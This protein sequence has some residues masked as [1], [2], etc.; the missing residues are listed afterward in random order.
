MIDGEQVNIF[1]GGRKL[2]GIALRE[3][4]QAREASPETRP[5]RSLPHPGLP[6]LPFSTSH[7]ARGE[8]LALPALIASLQGSFDCACS[9]R[10]LRSAQ[11]DRVSCAGTLVALEHWCWSG[12]L[13]R[14]LIW[15]W[16]GIGPGWPGVLVRGGPSP[17]CPGRCLIFRSDNLI[18]RHLRVYFVGPCGYASGQVI[19]F[20]EAG[21]AE[22]LDCLGAAAAHLTVR[23]DLAAGV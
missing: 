18:F 14:I 21:L 16:P 12:V 10:S 1:F 20:F 8:C 5:S 11:D 19:D 3:I 4:L 17:C 13:V 2:K 23:Y 6:H 9:L 7:D 22:K 15:G